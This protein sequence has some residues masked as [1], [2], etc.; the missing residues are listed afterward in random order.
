MGIMP[1][2]LSLLG[3]AAE[4]VI[5]VFHHLAS[6]VADDAF[7]LAEGN[8]PVEAAASPISL[9]PLLR[10]KLVPLNAAD[11]LSISLLTV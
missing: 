7:W 6:V 4:F 3:E 10:L 5:V 8:E 9:S 11:N 2:V 1:S